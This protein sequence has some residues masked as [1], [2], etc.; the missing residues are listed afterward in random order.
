MGAI[1]AAVVTIGAVIALLVRRML[2]AGERDYR[3]EPKA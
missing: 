2:R 3:E 1:I